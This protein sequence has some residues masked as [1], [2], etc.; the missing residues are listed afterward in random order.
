MKKLDMLKNG[1]RVID[2]AEDIVL[3][4]WGWNDHTPY[5][6][7]RVD[8]EGNA[9]KGH[10]FTVYTDAVRDFRDRVE[11]VQKLYQVSSL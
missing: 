10:Y 9:Y 6:T 2:Q 7:W 5:V 11:R 4:V 3:C 8:P 1:A